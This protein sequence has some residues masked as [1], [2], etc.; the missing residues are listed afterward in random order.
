[1]TCMQL[2]ECVSAC[3]AGCTALWQYCTLVLTRSGL[4]QGCVMRSNV[5]KISEKDPQAVY[6]NLLTCIGYVIQHA[7]E[8]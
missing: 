8:F 5:V 6:L 4:L 7:L 2:S 1:M 3:A